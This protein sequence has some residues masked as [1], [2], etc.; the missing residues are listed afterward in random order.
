[1]SGEN[2][3]TAQPVHQLFGSYPAGDEAESS[4]IL[5]TPGEFAREHLLYVQ[6][7]GRLKS[8]RQHSHHR[9]GVDS[10]L[11]VMVLAGR[12]SFTVGGTTWPMGENDC[13][14]LDCRQAYS[15]RSDDHDPWEMRWVH[16]DGGAAAAYCAC[17]AEQAESPVFHTDSPGDYLSLIEQLEVLHQS[18]TLGA[19]FRMSRMLT[20]LLTLCMTSRLQEESEEHGRME[21]VR[22]YIDGHLQERLSLTF[23]AERFYMSK[24][25]LARQFR[26]AY[27]VTVGEYISSRRITYAKE[28]L[29]FT[30]KS[31]EAIAALCGIP[32]TNYFAKVFRKIEGCSASEYRKKW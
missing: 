5:H 6:E 8:I 2:N 14:L 19:E 11:F 16:F 23:I 10:C 28:L 4:R 18:G 31:V 3:R 13:I 32:D 22:T 17:Y 9:E 7:A 1:M 29:R 30:D 24:F 27:G 20:D 12:G 25:Y 15:H 26:Q 21:A